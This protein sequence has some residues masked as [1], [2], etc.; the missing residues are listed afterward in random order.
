MNL[1]T[2]RKINGYGRRY[3]AILLFLCIVVAACLVDHTPTSRAFESPR[4]S[5]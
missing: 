2:K 5:G 1:Q 3:A 4:S